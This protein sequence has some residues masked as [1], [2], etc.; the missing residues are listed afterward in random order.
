[1]IGLCEDHIVALLA[2]HRSHAAVFTRGEQVEVR[3]LVFRQEFGVGIEVA[4]HTLCGV[5]HQLIG[6][7]FVDIEKRDL[8][9]HVD[10]E[11]H[12]AA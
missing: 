12:V 7:D 4:C 9:H 10:Q 1:M 6:V 3:H 5:L 2:D 11:F 8:P